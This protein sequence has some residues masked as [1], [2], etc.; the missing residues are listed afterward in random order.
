M[1]L[2]MYTSDILSIFYIKVTYERDRDGQRILY[3][4]DRFKGMKFVSNLINADSGE[5]VAEAGKK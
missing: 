4:S 1:A 3:S 5:I 2:R